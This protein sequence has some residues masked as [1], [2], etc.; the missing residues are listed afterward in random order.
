MSNHSIDFDD[1][2]RCISSLGGKEVHVVGDTIVDS[3]TNASMI[4]GQTKTPTMSVLFENKLDFVG[5]AGVVAK[6]LKAAGASVKFTTL[7]GVDDYANFVVDDL[8]RA[9]VDVDI[10]SDAKRPT[11]NK[12]AIVAGG[13]RLLKLDTLDNSSISDQKLGEFCESIAKTT[14]DAIVFSDFVM[15]L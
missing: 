10:K 1:I 9:G 11:T 2:R 8:T 7:L 5:G 3:I 4:G 6:H 13:Y 15:E 14:A 12:N